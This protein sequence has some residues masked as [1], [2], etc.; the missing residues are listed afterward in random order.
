MNHSQANQLILGKPII[1]TINLQRH[2]LWLEVQITV[3][4]ILHYLDADLL[5][6]FGKK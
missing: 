3:H 2:N 5:G 6:V 4:C 1:L